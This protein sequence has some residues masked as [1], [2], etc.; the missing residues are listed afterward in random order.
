MAEL[1]AVAFGA[2]VIVPAKVRAPSWRVVA[3][4]VFK[5]APAATVVD[6]LADKALVTAKVPVVTLTFA[7]PAAPESVEVPALFLRRSPRPPIWLA[8][9]AS[10]FCRMSLE[11]AARETAP[12]PKS[13]ALTM[14]MS[15]PMTSTPAVM[16]LAESKVS[17]P[18]PLFWIPALAPRARM[19]TFVD[20]KSSVVSVRIASGAFGVYE[21]TR[22]L[23]AALPLLTASVR[24]QVP[25][26]FNQP[27]LSI[28]KSEAR[29]LLAFAEAEASVRTFQL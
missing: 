1:P 7:K 19:A 29:T 27:E 5:V 14:A 28:V 4:V 12:V 23:L 26:E 10:V 17:R 9:A 13:P 25:S 3:P 18:V 11:P 6:T 8:M 22:L 20:V 2:P 21:R 24:A 15:P 16:I